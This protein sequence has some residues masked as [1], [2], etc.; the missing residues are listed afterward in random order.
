MISENTFRK[1]LYITN[2][3]VNIKLDGYTSSNEILD[4]LFDVSEV[5]A[6]MKHLHV[7]TLLFEAG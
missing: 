3:S 2:S 7:L 4:K 6:A 1:V 5:V